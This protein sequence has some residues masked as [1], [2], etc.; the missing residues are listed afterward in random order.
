MKRVI[1]MVSRMLILILA[2]SQC[3]TAQTYTAG[4]GP[5]G[6]YRDGGMIKQ[7]WYEVAVVEDGAD[8]LVGVYSAYVYYT[9]KTDF[10][11]K[12]I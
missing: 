11:T 3:A 1:R 10:G 2:L 6:V 8:D 5:Y 7:A 4:S 12:V 9:E